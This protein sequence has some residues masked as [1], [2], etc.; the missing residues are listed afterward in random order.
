MAVNWK[1]RRDQ[2][3][4]Y[5]RK[6]DPVLRDVID[7]VGPCKLRREQNRS[8]MLVR[9]IVSQQISAS[10]AKAIIARLC[11]LTAPAKP[12]AYQLH[13]LSNDD[14]RKV[15]ISPQKIGYLRHLSTQV[16]CGELELN[17]LGRKSDENVIAELTQIRG[18]G[19]WTAKMFLIFSL[20]RL[21]VFPHEDMGVRAA[22]R[23]RYGLADLPN[24]EEGVGIARRWRP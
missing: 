4:N 6:A 12:D 23:D 13:N 24:Q 2:G 22:I 17:T 19:V 7:S 16:V 15:G 8:Y 14:Y 10:A 5:L 1:S 11:A 9:A 3:V 18:I 20:G 21:D